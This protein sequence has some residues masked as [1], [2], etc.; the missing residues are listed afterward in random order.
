MFFYR[1]LFSALLYG[2]FVNVSAETYS[3]GQLN[4]M[5]SRGGLQLLTGN[6]NIDN[7]YFARECAS[8]I[9]FSCTFLPQQ[10]PSMQTPSGVPSVEDFVNG[11]VHIAP[12]PSSSHSGGEV[13]QACVDRA[14][15][16]IYDS[17]DRGG[18]GVNGTL[19]LS[20]CYR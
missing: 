4:Q 1:Y 19:M 12:S 14:K 18:A 13:D 7:Q 11:R 20:R 8:G 6:P 15:K 2:V 3:I 5:R 17:I 10:P 9:K 16:M